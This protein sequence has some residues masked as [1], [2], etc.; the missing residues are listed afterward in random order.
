M[1]KYEKIHDEGYLFTQKFVGMLGKL[2]FCM[3]DLYN[4]KME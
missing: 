1:Q 3:A 2:Y 4:I